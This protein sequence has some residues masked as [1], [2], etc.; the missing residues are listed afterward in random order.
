MPALLVT[1]FITTACLA[2][3]PF[4]E[5]APLARIAIMPAAD[6]AA[7]TIKGS[8]QPLLIKGF[9]YVRLR[10][11]DHATFEA[12]TKAHTAYYDPQQAEAMFAALEADGFNTVRVFIIG[13]APTINP[14]IAGE[15]EET[16][17]IYAPY[18]E[19]V[20]DFLRRAQRHHSYVLLAFGDGEVPANRY[21]QSMLDKAH[22]GRNGI[23]FTQ[24]G[25][26]AKVAYVGDVLNYIKARELGLL[27]ALLGIECQNELLVNSGE[28]PFTVTQGRLTMPN[29]KTYDMADSNQRRAL[30]NEGLKY[31]HEAVVRRVKQ[32]DPDLLVAESVFT[33]ALAGKS[34]RSFVGV[35][36]GTG[37]Y[38][39]DLVAMGHSSL[40]FL[41]I[42][43]YR[44]H[45]QL[46]LP[47][48]FAFQM[49]SSL[50]DTPEM[51]RIRQ[52]TPV[53]MGEF[54]AFRNVERD[55]SEV[56]ANMVKTRDMALVAGLKGFLYW[57]Y[58]SVEQKGL[59]YATE[60]DGRLVKKLAR[61]P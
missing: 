47:S 31:Y 33:V 55:Y 1:L 43:F 52:T 59:Y 60:D 50:L 38:P 4:L 40:D 45:K 8:G 23:Y 58:D 14:G 51:M 56:V 35:R 13:R 3:P 12:A 34:A 57:T 20:L 42:H 11:G 39:P 48:C 29:G 49:R 2:G 5:A 15:V 19:N 30:M 54:G 7:F 44:F 46:V 41:D 61:I 22:P 16:H 32:I 27:K 9:N 21:Y 53:F 6:G 36:A 10:G 18:M 28:W 17:G 26:N 37:N 25:I 24:A